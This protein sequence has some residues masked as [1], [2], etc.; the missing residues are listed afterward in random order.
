MDEGAGIHQLK[1][2]G[3]LPCLLRIGLARTNVKLSR[4]CLF[5]EN[6]FLSKLRRLKMKKS[7]RQSFVNYIMQSSITSRGVDCGVKVDW[8][9]VFI[10]SSSSSIDKGMKCG[11]KRSQSFVRECPS[12]LLCP[13]TR[14]FLKRKKRSAFFIVGIK[15]RYG[16]VF[17]HCTEIYPPEE[18]MQHACSA[19]MSF[20]MKLNCK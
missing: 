2:W 3:L 6:I 16:Q 19:L 8:N 18:D 20:Y 11:K 13:N 15:Q 10:I 12:S 4:S 9:I 7:L 5:T 1:Q 14:G 17:P